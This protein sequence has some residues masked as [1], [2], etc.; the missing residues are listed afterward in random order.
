MSTQ[1]RMIVLVMLLALTAL[2]LF[3]VLRTTGGGSG[4]DPDALMRQRRPTAPIRPAPG[5]GT[6]LGSESAPDDGDGGE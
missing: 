2:A 3:M 6:E 1:R 4:N 5:Q